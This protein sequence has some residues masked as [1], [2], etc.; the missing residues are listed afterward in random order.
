MCKPERS[1]CNNTTFREVLPHLF[2]P[3]NVNMN[4]FFYE[5]NVVLIM[6]KVKLSLC[7][8]N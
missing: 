7:L 4:G 8:I 3:G 2:Y 1:R 5:L 6:L